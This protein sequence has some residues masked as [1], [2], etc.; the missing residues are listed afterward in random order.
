MM[1]TLY[2]LLLTAFLTVFMMAA[3]PAAY[4]QLNEIPSPATPS[5]KEEVELYQH[6][7]GKIS[8]DVTI[9]DRK[10]ATLVQPEGREWRE[11]RNYWSRIIS[12]VMIVGMLAGLGALFLFPG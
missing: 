9:P 2:R 3:A 5:S 1:P 6:L 12:G 11:F 8:G 4:A 7:K 10:L